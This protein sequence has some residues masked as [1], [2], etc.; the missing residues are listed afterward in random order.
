MTD[1]EWSGVWLSLQ[2]LDSNEG[3]WGDALI[4]VT[5]DCAESEIAEYEWVE[6]AADDEAMTEPLAK[7]GSG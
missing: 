1:Q 6:Y 7:S 5:L 4:Q 2:P 3:A